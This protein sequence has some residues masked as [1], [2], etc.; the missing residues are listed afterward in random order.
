[1]TFRRAAWLLPAVFAAYP[2][3]AVVLTQQ[4]LFNPVFHAGTTVAWGRYSPGLATR[5]GGRP[6]GVHVRSSVSLAR[7]GWYARQE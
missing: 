6:P 5:V 7:T 4:A 2:Y 1:M 3:Y